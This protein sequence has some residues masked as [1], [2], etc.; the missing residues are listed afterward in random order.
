MVNPASLTR[1]AVSAS[2]SVLRAPAQ[3]GRAVPKWAPRSPSPAAVS[4]ASQTAWAATSPSEWPARP[5]SPGQS[6][7]ARYNGRPSP[8]GWTSV[9]TPTCG[10]T[11]GTVGGRQ[12]SGREDLVEQ[13]LG[14]VLVGLLGQGKLADEDLPCLGEHALLP[15]RQTALPV[16]APQI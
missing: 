4:R 6:S 15:G 7:P 5:V 2:S 14:L 12:K 9:P 11:P 3:R 1:R 10:N 8:N 13:R 16:P